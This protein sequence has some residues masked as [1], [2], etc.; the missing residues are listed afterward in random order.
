MEHDHKKNLQ[1]NKMEKR[2]KNIK[3]LVFDVDGVMTDGGILINSDGELYR[4]F[5][6]KDSLALR[7]AS[8]V[9]YHLGCITGATAT[10]I[11]KRLGVCGFKKE[12]IY[13]SSRNKIVDFNNFCKRHSLKSEEV[14]Y[15]G[16]DLPDIS[17]IQAAG[18]G[19]C[20]SDAVDEVKEVADYISPYGGGKLFIRKAIEMVMK[21]QGKWG[22]DVENYTN[23][24]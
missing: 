4:F 19:I 24:F 1:D 11:V 15:F 18:I 12:D 7:L 22:F 6:A 3:A 13:L 9:P 8:L 14:M 20:P 16:D 2:L 10:N 17:V 5:D 23:K 21:A